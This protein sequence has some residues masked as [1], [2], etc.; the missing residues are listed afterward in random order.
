MK[1]SNSK[2]MTLVELMIVV[3]IIAII[4]LIAFPSY[5]EFMRKGRRADGKNKLMEIAS[6][7]ERFYSDTGGYGTLAVVMGS[8]TVDSD[9]GYYQVSATVGAGLRPQTYLLTA[10]PQGGQ[11]GDTKCGNLTL[12]QAAAKGTSGPDTDGKCW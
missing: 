8:A 11:S 5:E 1:R 7:Q 6:R 4:G 10:T 2:G 3:A 12:D 9:D